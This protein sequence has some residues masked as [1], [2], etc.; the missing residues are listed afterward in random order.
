MDCLVV[1]MTAGEIREALEGVD[2]SQIFFGVHRGVGLAGSLARSE[3]SAL[4]AGSACRYTTGIPSSAWRKKR[5]TTRLRR[6]CATRKTSTTSNRLNF[7]RCAMGAERF[8]SP[9]P[10]E[11]S[12]PC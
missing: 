11:G 6:W 8:L 4:S 7:A 12:C 3:L 5:V 2:D 10:N 9:D 1:S